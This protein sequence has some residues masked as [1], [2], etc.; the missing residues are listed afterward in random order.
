MQ[1]FGS[2]KPPMSEQDVRHMLGDVSGGDFCVWRENKS[3]DEVVKTI[4][5]G[6]FDLSARTISLYSDNPSETEPHCRL[7][8]LF[9]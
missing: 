7:P 2:Y 5:V 6:I 4:A 8:L 9:K 1:T 3:C